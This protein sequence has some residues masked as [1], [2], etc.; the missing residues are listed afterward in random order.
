MVPP[1]TGGLR[2]KR[3]RVGRWTRGTA[4]TVTDPAFA[5]GKKAAANPVVRAAAY[6]SAKI[7]YAATEATSAEMSIAVAGSST[8]R[9]VRSMDARG[10]AVV[11]SER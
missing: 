8:Q 4:I 6:S 1:E 10:A 3:A 5:R 11:A 7:K 2:G 9:L